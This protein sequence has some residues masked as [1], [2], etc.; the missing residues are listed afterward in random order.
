MKK[1]SVRSLTVNLLIFIRKNTNAQQL[2]KKSCE[3]FFLN[4]KKFFFNNLDEQHEE[5]R[6]LDEL[7]RR[8]K[9]DE[10]RKEGKTFSVGLCDNFNQLI[11]NNIIFRRKKISRTKESQRRTVP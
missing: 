8:Q 7:N 2:R 9:E 3:I 4:F 1:R 6:K 10:L 11:F 5:K